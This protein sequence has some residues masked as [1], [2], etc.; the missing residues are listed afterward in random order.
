VSPEKLA[1]AVARLASMIGEDRIGMPVTVDSHRPDRY[2]LGNYEPPAPPK[3]STAPKNSRAIA[4]V[5]AFRT[6]IPIEVVL[7]RPNDDEPDSIQ[8]ESIRGNDEIHGDVRLCSGP[9]QIEEGWWRENPD[10]HEYW[11]VE[12][13]RGTYRIYENGEW[14]ADGKYD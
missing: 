11:D 1:A 3:L 12:L 14:F 4:T 8:I 7:R 10:V 5:R 9:W 2:A 13:E 6:P